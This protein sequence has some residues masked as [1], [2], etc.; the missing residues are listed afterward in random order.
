VNVLPR[1]FAAL[2]ALFA[3]FL[4]SR[5]LH[6]HYRRSHTLG[7]LIG[8]GVAPQAP[9]SLAQALLS[10][11]RSEAEALLL[12]LH[13]SKHGISKER[14]ATV[15]RRIGPNTVERD[16]PLPAWQHLWRCYRNPFNLLLTGLSVVSHLTGDE[17]A[18]L[19]IGTMVALSTLLR[20]WQEYR[21]HQA[22]DRLKSMVSNTATVLRPAGLGTDTNAQ[23]LQL[24]IAIG[25]LVPGDVVKVSAGDMMPA[26]LRV[27]A[28]NDLFIN[29][30]AM[31]GESLPVERHAGVPVDNNPNPL[32]CSNLLFM[33][34]S[35]VSGSA[36]AVVVGTGT[37]TYM[38][39]LTQRVN[40]TETNPDGNNAFQVGVNQVSWLL[41]RFMMVM[42][43][44][45]LLI[46]G[47]TKHDWLQALLFAL[48]I[49][50]GLTPEML[51][52]I[53]TTTLAK[54]A[55]MLS[56]RKVIVK[57]LDAIQ[58][59]GAMD[60]LCTDKTGTLTQDHIALNVAID[61]YGH[62][63]DEVLRMAYLNSHFQTGLKNL[64]DVA[65]LQHAD[66][67]HALALPG[68]WHLIDEIPFDFQRRRM[69]V[70]VGCQSQP[71]LL[72][73]KGAVEEV[74]A[75]CTHVQ[76]G[77]DVLPL[78]P[79]EMSRIAGRTVELN[80]EGLRVVAVARKVLAPEL[81][82]QP[83]TYHARDETG[84]TL[85]GYLAF[86]DP[87]KESTAPAL[88]ALRAHGVTVKI[89]TGDS[90]RVT[91]KVCRDVGLP[92]APLLLGSEIEAMDDTALS[93][94]VEQTH[95]FAK[96]TPAHKDRVVSCLRTN[97]HVVGFMGDGINDAAALRAADVGISVDTAV[98]IAK[99]AADIILLEKSLLVLDAGVMEGRKT[100]ANL[101]KYIRMTASSNFGNVLSVLAA[102][103]FLPFLPMLP[104]H[105]LLQN[106]LYDVSQI[107]IPFDRVDAEQLST[108]Q[109]WQPAELGRF[110]L[111]FG[112]ISS[113]FDIATFVL[114]T[115]VFHATT[116]AQQTLFQSGWFVE[117]LLTQSLV[118]HLIR[119]RKIPFIESRSSGLLFACTVAVMLVGL[120]L[121]MGFLAGALK[122]Q[123]LPLT[124]F[125]WLAAML[126]CYAATVQVV[127]GWYGRRYWRTPLQPSALAL[128][129][130]NAD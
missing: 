78:T 19:I 104:M 86:L 21:S 129:S 58:N 25:K 112:P 77:D 55:V 59:L 76:Q 51:P 114:M 15:R 23:A 48:A 100:F 34:T 63:G 103:A 6:R 61:A 82:G 46:N 3:R 9:H 37:Q 85:V 57:R 44:A 8:K 52:M 118:V 64:L 98:D 49:A 127:R 116:P 128:T 31:S 110:M 14:A 16:K 12:H 38:G 75:V 125:G 62:A 7:S 111:V 109:H 50:V 28:A 120:W 113:L 92:D 126:L 10:A 122:L 39:A 47:F 43:P 73:C 65:V 67:H 53:A 60:V 93:L 81:P 107:G 18:A 22:A 74:L 71:P 121:P 2:S 90:D 27:L 97:G 130:S 83:L 33:G 94:A 108:P 29:Q 35:V 119:T 96:L 40:A 42:V 68:A 13:S 54:G 45:V 79:A 102:S 17:N 124:Y 36:T 106:L 115:V 87:P 70:V 4:K 30:S 20:F 84:L 69:S 88:A 117:G 101:L 89:L 91:R 26:D 66:L 32:E 105:L 24:E 95:I 99:D 80:D 41:I 5:A 56:R 1:R 11:S 72:I 123:P